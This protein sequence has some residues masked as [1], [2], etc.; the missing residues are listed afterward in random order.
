MD[1]VVQSLAV[2]RRLHVLVAEDARVNRAFA[3]ALLR[4]L[5]HT[6][7]TA[8]NGLDAYFLA[9]QVRFDAILMDC[10]MPELD[11]FEATRKIRLE[12]PTGAPTSRQVRIIAVTAHGEPGDRDDCLAAGMDGY[13]TKPL[14]LE[15]LARELGAAGS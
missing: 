6:T 1:P 5:G 15:G 14:G 11:G 3:L 12:L 9:A 13:L 7:D 4:R 8:E 10:S 2:P